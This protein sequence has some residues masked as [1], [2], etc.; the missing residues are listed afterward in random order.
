MSESIEYC[1]DHVYLADKLDFGGDFT[2][3][4]HR[5]SNCPYCQLA[6]L[7]AQL[8]SAQ[9]ENEKWRAMSESNCNKL[10]VAATENDQL[11]TRCEELQAEAEESKT[12]IKYWQESQAYAENQYLFQV[13]YN[14]TQE[15]TIREYAAE[16]DQL[17]TRCEAADAE[18]K[19]FAKDMLNTL[20]GIV[21]TPVEGYEEH[22]FGWM[23][24]DIRSLRKK[25]EE[26]EKENA[27]LCAVIEEDSTTRAEDRAAGRTEG[28][29]LGLAEGRKEVERLKSDLAY[30]AKHHGIPEDN[31]NE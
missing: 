6:A 10:L 16:C 17:R 26:L 4:I 8:A 27:E 25:C 31:L 18:R 22:G 23:L 3:V 30:I 1:N 2:S 15:G 21:C 12:K 28:Y 5:K 11:R 7:Q 9:A 24:S 13:A 14:K 29:N 19:Q 20:A